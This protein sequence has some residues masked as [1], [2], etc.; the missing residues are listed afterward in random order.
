MVTMDTSTVASFDAWKNLSWKSLVDQMNETM[1][2]MKPAR[3][4][5]LTAR[6]NLAESTKQLKK[7]VKVCEQQ[8]V[9]ADA[10]QLAKE[11][12]NTVKSYQEE[13]DNLTKRCKVSEQAYQTITFMLNELPDPMILLNTIQQLQDEN[14]KL[15]SLNKKI[16]IDYDNEFNKRDN[17]FKKL[18]LDYKKLENDNKKLTNEMKN[19]VTKNNKRDSNMTSITKDEYEE[20]FKLRNEVIQYEMELRT[21]KNQDITVRKL[22][23][24]IEELQTTGAEI[25]N[26]SIEQ[27]KNELSNEY[28]IRINE[29]YEQIKYNEIQIQ[30]LQYQLN[31]EKTGNST[32]QNLLL[33]NNDAAQNLETTFNIQK[34]ILLNDNQR[35]REDYTILNKQY[36]D[37]LL[38]VAF[39]ENNNNTTKGKNNQQDMA[40]SGSINVNASGANIDANSI[41]SSSYNNPTAPVSSS[42]ILKSPPISG[43]G[44]PSSTASKQDLLLERNAYEAEVAELS[45]TNSLLREELRIRDEKIMQIKN[46]YDSKIIELEDNLTNMKKTIATLESQLAS[47]PSHTL[48]SSMKRELRILKRLEYNAHPEMTGD[49]YNDDHTHDIMGTD[50]NNNDGNTT[51]GTDDGLESVLIAKLRRTESEL[52]TERTA[53]N[54]LLQAID[55]LNQQLNL[56]L[57]AKDDVDQL[58]ISLEKDLERAINT[59]SVSDTTNNTMKV[60]SSF[61]G[62]TDNDVI[63]PIENPNTLQSILDPD[64]PT[65][66][67]ELDAILQHQSQQ[68]QTAVD[69]DHNNNEHSVATIIMA[70]RDRLRSRCEVLEAERDSFKRELQLQVQMTESYKSDNTKLY[71]K[72]RYLQNYNQS[73]SNINNNNGRRLLHN[74]GNNNDGNIR[75]LDLE[76]LE[77]RY[78]AS[79]DPFK[80]FNKA[81]RQRKLN[82]MSSM[83]R[84]VFIVAKT[85]L[86]TKEMRTGLFVY[87]V[88]LHF[89]V[90]MTTY[91]WSHYGGDCSSHF[92]NLEHMAHLPPDLPE[93]AATQN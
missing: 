71:E 47:A 61:S 23:A 52:I 89:L 68:K 25:L 6:K 55:Q 77:Q 66:S 4:Q 93:D 20:L 74:R 45:E 59:T 33:Q 75:D 10:N 83:E 8:S 15:H 82:E 36:N 92:N 62:T 91:H 17:D 51:T 37:M 69:N 48:V 29:L 72:V 24:K 28:E 64:N 42:F 79:V 46:D 43:V 85:V 54:E 1:N 22:E 21:L 19:M 13:I 35:L 27:V 86:S 44:L 88:T 18:E 14:Q 50:T 2:Q 56:T 30:N 40:F 3:E 12:K 80:Q 65:P 34:N 84:T 9:N 38:K 73:C 16:E 32:F 31:I 70:Q 90:F 78:E 41:S 58:V 7:L 11:S 76:A 39:Y 87:V 57:K 81:E 26:S 60:N 5:S 53:K 67:S 49:P 63:I